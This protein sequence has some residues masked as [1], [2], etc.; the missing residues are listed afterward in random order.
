MS[1]ANCGTDSKGRKIGYAHKATCDHSG[2]TESI[3]RGLSYACGG[4]HGESSVY[5]EKYFCGE[6]L[7]SLE[8]DNNALASEGINQ[9][10]DFCYEQARRSNFV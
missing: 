1:W 7:N 4:D 10:C 2:C 5:C 6:H 9:L 3:D 8:D